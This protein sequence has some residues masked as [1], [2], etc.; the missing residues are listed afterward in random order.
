MVVLR[1]FDAMT[2]RG[3]PQPVNP[4][5]I[6]NR[7]QREGRWYDDAQSVKNQMIKEARAQGMRRDDAQLWAYGELQRMYP[8]LPIEKKGEG[9]R[10]ESDDSPT[11]STARSTGNGAAS[12]RIQGL[13]DIPPSWPDLA[14]NASIQAELSWVQAERLRVVSESSSGATRVHLDRARSPAP[15]LAALGWLETSIRSYAKYIDIAT[16]A[17]STTQD[18]QHAARRERLDMDEMHSLIDAMTLG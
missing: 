18:D 9:G 15:S 7:L 5:E 13:G 12:A 8:P 4:A 14:G 16:R 2:D 11:A 3:P 6:A 17:L 1:G 10:G